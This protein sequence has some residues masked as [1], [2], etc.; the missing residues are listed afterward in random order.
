V[1]ISPKIP[2]HQLLKIH[3]GSHI[4]EIRYAVGVEKWDEELR[5]P[6]IDK[7]PS[8]EA[9]Y[10]SPIFGGKEHERLQLNERNVRKVVNYVKE[11]PRWNLSIQIHKILG[12]S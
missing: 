11:N 8:A 1:S 10:L 9:Y 2:V 4:D 3:V 5:I 7:L 12:F 6:D